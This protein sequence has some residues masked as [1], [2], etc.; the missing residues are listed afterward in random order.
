MP[1][2]MVRLPSFASGLSSV[3]ATGYQGM[4]L[5]NWV[6]RKSLPKVARPSSVMRRN[7]GLPLIEVALTSIVPQYHCHTRSC[8]PP[9]PVEH[10][11]MILEHVSSPRTRSSPR[12]LDDDLSALFLLSLLDSPTALL[13]QTVGAAPP[14]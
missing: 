9:P 7:T 1:S 5:N 10:M 12:T 4:S 3:I 6:G 2:N 8:G 14:P 11:P 13:P